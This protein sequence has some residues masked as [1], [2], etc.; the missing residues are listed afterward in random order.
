V[1]PERRRH[2]RASARRLVCLAALLAAAP[3]F[4]QPRDPAAAQALFDEAKRL[5][6]TGRV[7]DACPKF[8]SSFRLDPKPGAA[9]NLG[10]CYEKNGQTASAWA[11]YLEA[12]SL[13][14]QAGQADRAAY[15]RA[16]AK[17]IEP[18]LA[19]LTVVVPKPAAGL[20]VRRDGVLIEA[21][22]WGMAVPVD[23]GQHVLEARAPAKRPWSRTVDVA[24]GG[25]KVS[26]EV[27]AMQDVA[28]R[29]EVPELADRAPPPVASGPSTRKIA[30]AVLMGA[31]VVGFVVGGA[32]VAA[33]HAQSRDLAAKCPTR[34]ACDPTLE[35]EISSYRAS[36]GGAIASFIAGGAVLGTGVA[37]FLTAPTAST[38]P[39]HDGD[40]AGSTPERPGTFVA[41]RLGLGTIG[42][43]GAF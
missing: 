39:V 10:A 34:T 32:L 2:P 13:A 20:E 17:A 5:L 41:P 8:L 16:A 36:G 43:E 1:V 37:V 12:A 6:E 25:A 7:A 30:G 3:A 23:P 24:A 40:S 28:A 21:T 42:I 18:K 14:E 26:I 29:I 9:F 15:A 11:R 33:A 19:R 4:A 35:P 22:A 38:R 27:P 31:S